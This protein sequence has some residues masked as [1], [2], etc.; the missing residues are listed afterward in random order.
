[1]IKKLLSIA[2]SALFIIIPLF[3]IIYFGID[4]GYSQPP[5][6]GGGGGGE[7]CCWPAPCTCIPID[8]GIGFLIA[9]GIVYGCKKA[10]DSLKNK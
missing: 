10:Y 2:I 3:I 5:P 9:A 1:M 6:P 8:G 7:P 4:D